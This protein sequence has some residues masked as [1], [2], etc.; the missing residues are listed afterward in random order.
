MG[1]LRTHERSCSRSLAAAGL[2]LALAAATAGGARAQRVESDVPYVPTNPPTVEAMLRIA[3]VGPNDLVMDLGS[4]DGRIVITAARRYG[5]RGLGVELDPERVRESIAN[6]RAAGVSERVRFVQGDLFEADI[7]PAT[8]VTL[9]LLSRV[10]LALRPRLLNELRPGTRIVSHDFDMG[11]WK[12]DIR[13]SVRGYGS[14]IFFWVVPA[15][16][17]GTWR[18]RIFEPAGEQVFDVEFKQQFQEIEG[19]V[20]GDGPKLWVRDERLEGERIVF[21]LI[22]DRD[23]KHRRNFE[24]IV[25]GEEMQGSATGEGSAPRGPYR[26]RAVRIAP[27]SS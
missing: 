20:R 1:G 10:N 27:R 16:V 4:G 9:Y 19:E 11:A 3:N 13:A 12:P 26:W 17:A 8:V 21:A 7:R 15:K 6:A 22:P 14:E 23:W 18:V 24:G 2:A 25:R 5:A